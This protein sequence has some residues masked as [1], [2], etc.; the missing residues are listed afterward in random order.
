MSEAI[1]TTQQPQGDT[2]PDFGSAAPPPSSGGKTTPPPRRRR[3]PKPSGE[4]PSDSSPPPARPRAPRQPS[5]EKQLEEFFGVIAVAIGTT[6]DMYCAGVVAAQT[7]P[8]AEAWGELARKNDRV[9]EII[10]RM[11]QG[12]TWGG[13][14]FATMVT[15]IPIAAHHNLWPKGMPMPFDF[16]I[17]PPP[18]PSDEVA[19]EHQRTGHPSTGSP[20]VP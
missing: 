10:E 2:P 5:I 3:Q 12:S 1:E 16:G 9:R 19:N 7:K 4:T 8:L 6:G 15:V 17:G 18:P 13:V 14:I 20:P 11:M